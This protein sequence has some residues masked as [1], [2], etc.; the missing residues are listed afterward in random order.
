MKKIWKRL[1]IMLTSHGERGITLVESLIA[2]AVL[3]GGILTLV[4]C[5]SSG[6][7]AVNEND[8]Q[9]VA[10]GLVRAQLEHTKSYAYDSGASTYPTVSPPSGYSVSVNVTAVPG[11][12]SDIQK[13]TATVTYGGAAIMAAE[14][15]KVN[16]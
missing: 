10:Q 7:L 6:A 8:R 2:V 5:M 15:Y 1:H 11:A 4:L 13:I 16:R 9:S 14:D 3:G 12:D